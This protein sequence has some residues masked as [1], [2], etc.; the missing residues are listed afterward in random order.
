MTD[1]NRSAT[2]GHKTMNAA[3]SFAV[4]AAPGPEWRAV[5]ALWFPPHLAGAD[6]VTH[7]AM[8]EFWFAGGATRHLA[9][10]AELVDAATRHELDHWRTTPAGRL[11][12]ILLLDQFP[13]GLFAGRPEAYAGDAHALRLA[14]EGLEIGHYDALRTSWEKTFFFMPLAHAEGPFHLRRLKR[15]VRLA[16]RIAAEAPPRL[17]PLYEFSASQ[18]RAHLDV[19]RRF[20]RYPHR[21]AIF[22][23]CSTPEE[24]AY[25]AEGKLVH[26]RRPP[27]IGPAD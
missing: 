9:P 17:R 16:E 3:T 10:F 6:A 22:G 18:P 5:H 15:V 4:D 20:G 7:R 13:R 1:R 26:Q 24:L 11:S 2:Q 21:N 8:F 14:L 12:L 23:R 27:E 19:I 25:L